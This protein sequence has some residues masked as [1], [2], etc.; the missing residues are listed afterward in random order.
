M[1]IR[2]SIIVLAALL[3]VILC[4]AALADTVTFTGT[5]AASE[6]HEIYAPIGGTVESVN[7]DVGQK[8]SA[9]DTLITLSTTKIYAEEDGVVTGV[10]GQLGDSAETVSQKYGAVM[11]I[12]GESVYAIAASTDNAYNSTETKFVHVGEEVYLECYSDGKHTGTGVITAIEGTDYTVK[13]LSGEF[14]IG[15]TVNVYR[16]DTATSTQRIGRGTLNRQNPT[17]VTGAGSIVSFAVQAGDTVHRGDLLFETLEGSFDGLYMS[18]V[19]IDADVDGVLS[20]IDAQQGQNTQKGAVVATLWPDSAMRVEAEIEE[21][22][23]GAIAVG[24][25]V[26]IELVWNQDD[27]ITYAGTVSMISAIA[28]SSAGID[29]DSSV[30][31]TVYIDFTPD[32]NTR[33]GMSAIV[34][35]LDE[36]E[37]AVEREEEGT[38]NTEENAIAEGRFPSE[39]FDPDNL[40]ENFSRENLP[41]GF[42]PESFPGTDG[43]VSDGAQD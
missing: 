23:L 2:K 37:E 26:S 20:Q 32:A 29:G 39:G 1:K 36:A 31:Y 16:G 18:G 35:T 8:V 4:Q 21:A 41:E 13:V 6:T 3:A 28:N 7:A 14:L 11:Y 19:E 40:P 42:D 9:G 38:E 10:F 5:V 25:P 15:E 43:E 30:T 33:Y 12:E 17:A 34:T 27:E 24:D 22:N